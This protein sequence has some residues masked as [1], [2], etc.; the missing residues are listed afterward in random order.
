MER[1]TTVKEL[2]Q[3]LLHLPEDTLVAGTAA[4]AN[5]LQ[6]GNLGP[7]FVGPYPGDDRTLLFTVK[8]Q[9]MPGS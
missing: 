6:L 9:Q 4:D 7:V 3:A 5:N 1:I 2:R 8:A